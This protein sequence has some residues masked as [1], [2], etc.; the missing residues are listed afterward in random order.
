[1]ATKTQKLSVTKGQVSRDA[2]HVVSKQ[3][4]MFEYAPEEKTVGRELDLKM[5]EISLT[6]I[7]RE[8]LN[9]D[10][11]ADQLVHLTRKY[12]PNPAITV[13]YFLV[14]RGVVVICHPPQSP[15]LEAAGVFLYSKVKTAS[16]GADFWTSRK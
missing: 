15:D 11:K 16:H 9:F 6:N 5:L 1:M 13:K 12:S 8:T 10:I 4:T 7:S 14:N 2:V 3:G